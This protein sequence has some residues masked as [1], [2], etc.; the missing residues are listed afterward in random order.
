MPDHCP[1]S[2]HLYGG[3]HTT[4]VP[5]RVAGLERALPIIIGRDSW[6]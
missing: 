3:T 1:L 5:E 4:A 6:M 2:V